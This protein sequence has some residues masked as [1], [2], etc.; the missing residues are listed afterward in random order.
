[1]S[2][3]AWWSVT[4]LSAVMVIAGFGGDAARVALRYERLAILD[5][6]YWRLLTGHLVHLGWAHLLLNLAG[7]AAVSALFAAELTPLRWAIVLLAAVLAIDAGF[8]LLLPGLAW[9]VGFSGVLH[10]LFAAGAVRG[11]LQG[12]P[13]AWLL[14][15]LLVAKLAWE[16]LI[17]PLPLTEGAAG[18]PVVEQAHLYGAAGGVLAAIAFASLSVTR[19]DAVRL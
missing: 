1:M 4:A 18:G 16:G 7:L 10:G 15:G 8:L 6:E 17:G 14:A 12:R 13:D 2:R 19:G 11:C 3:S 5:G 9:Y